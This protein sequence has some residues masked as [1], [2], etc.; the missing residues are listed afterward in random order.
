MYT[1]DWVS[2][3]TDEK[4]TNWANWRIKRW[5]IRQILQILLYLLM[6]ATRAISYLVI[7]IVACCHSMKLCALA[8]RAFRSQHGRCHSFHKVTVTVFT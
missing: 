4:V 5:R 8:A 7:S 3:G 6:M 2:A 1:K